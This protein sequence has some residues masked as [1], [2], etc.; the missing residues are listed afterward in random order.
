MSASFIFVLFLTPMVNADPRFAPEKD[1]D[2]DGILNG[3]D[4]DIDGDG[5][6]EISTAKELYNVRFELEGGAY[7]S[8]E[9]R[10]GCGGQA[11]IE[12][13]NGYEL[14]ENI[15]LSRYKSWLPIGYTGGGDKS[16][17]PFT[18]IFEGN[19]YAV[20]GLQIINSSRSHAGLFAQ[21]QGEIRNLGVHAVEISNFVLSGD[22]YAGILVGEVTDD[23]IIKNSYGKVERDVSSEAS[24]SGEDSHSGGLIGHSRKS[25]DVDIVSSYALVKGSVISQV[26]S[27]VYGNSFSGGLMGRSKDDVNIV[28]SYAVVEGSVSS[29]APR[30]DPSSFIDGEDSYSGGL[31]GQMFSYGKRSHIVSSYA[32]VGGDIS[33]FSEGDSVY[34]GGLVGG[35]D[36]NVGIVSSYA[37]VGGSISSRS[38]SAADDSYSGGLVGDVGNV[39]G[40]RMN[41]ISSYA[42]VGR[43]I[44]SYSPF[45]SFYSYSYSSS[46]GLVGYIYYDGDIRINESF[47]IVEGDI[48]SG[49]EGK[50]R[51]GDLAGIVKSKGSFTSLNSSGSLSLSELKSRDS[52]LS[53]HT[54][55]AR[56]CDLD[57]KWIH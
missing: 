16:P 30:V 48:I 17:E 12:S 34:S 51:T 13:C 54:D 20:T 14:T 56:Y 5:L 15:D 26:S 38:R 39:D 55:D 32:M 25:A 33:S 44:S 27:S 31:V 35:I 53:T 28:S 7:T 2:G 8:E 46:G 47:S 45:D 4:I 10:Y 41:I 1:F 22:S 50:G 49:E 9:E 37:V 52:F 3:A 19:G 21:A 24:S 43:D 57:G 18:A 42:L 29:S 11:G 6:I 36:H 23:I 40:F